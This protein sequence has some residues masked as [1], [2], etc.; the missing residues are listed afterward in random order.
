MTS[1]VD[2]CVLGLRFLGR[3]VR[4]TYHALRTIPL[5]RVP[6]WRVVAGRFWMCIDPQDW[7]DR[8]FYLGSYERHLV[9]LIADTVRSG[10][11]CIDVGAQKGFITLNMAKATGPRGLVISV[12][13]DPRAMEALRANVQRNGFDQVR[14][15]SC[16]L[17]DSD[18]SCMFA[19][20]H[21]LGWS[22]RFPNDVARPTVA[23]TIAVRTRRLDDV[24][25]EAGVVPETHR[26]SL[27][28]IDAEG[29]EPLVLEGAQRTL[30]RFRPTVH[31]EVNNSSLSA[32]GYS[33]GS[34]E[35]LLR[36]LDYQLY[37]IH[38]GRLT[39]RL[40]LSPIT[41]LSTDIGGC[42]DVLAVSSPGSSVPVKPV[43]RPL[44]SAVTP[45]SCARGRGKDA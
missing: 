7:M 3:P 43:D 37:A 21:Q 34:I 36:S 18:S 19:L 41:S 5:G 42:E 23:R 39:R 9:H 10:D 32:G 12:E 24:I 22:S 2:K 1:F 27:L 26:I 35:T 11:V 38:W 45:K 8:A 6:Q 29:S 13:P 16:A 17:G 33:A 40:S 25:A 44:R 15:Y 4:S 20:S 31:I 14:L 28:K 30:E